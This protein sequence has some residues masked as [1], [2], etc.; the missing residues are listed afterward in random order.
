MDKLKEKLDENREEE[1][2]KEKT[3]PEVDENGKPIKKKRAL[4]KEE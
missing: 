1:E 2:K 4:T 3:E